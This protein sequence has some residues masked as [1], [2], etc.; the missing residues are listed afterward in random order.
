MKKLVAHG[1]HSKWEVRR[2]VANAAAFSRHEAFQA[3]LAKLAGDDNHLVRQAAQHASARRRDW[4]GAQALGKQHVEHIN[5]TLDDIEARFGPRGRA[6]VKRA[7]DEIANIY[8]RELYHEVIKLIS[9]L[10]ASTERLHQMLQKEKR[11]KALAKEAQRI[12]ER[13]ARLQAVI[14]A[15]RVYTAQP[16]LDFRTESLAAVLEESA[17]LAPH[18]IHTHCDEGAIAELDRTRMVQALVNL[19]HN[20]IESY[21]GEVGP[22]R[23]VA[24]DD[25]PRVIIRV[26]D[27]GAGMSE[28]VLRD[29]VT[30]FSTSKNEGTGF[31]LP[32]AIKIVEGEHNGQL[33]LESEEG[34]GTRVIVV[35]PKRQPR[36]SPS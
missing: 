20:A 9:P 5:S 13:V 11:S 19:L 27:E 3:V 24:I 33:S 17:A 10:A 14:G 12:G 1:A 8:S 30:L 36:G 26:E 16:K 31:G 29:A 15:M 34:K 6:A 22:V 18:A 21:E 25:G 2:E 4:A 35:L 23:L 28:E 7:A 32:L